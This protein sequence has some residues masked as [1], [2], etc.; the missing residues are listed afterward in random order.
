MD[1]VRF[2]E[3]HEGLEVLF[4]DVLIVGLQLPDDV[5]PAGMMVVGVVPVLAKEVFKQGSFVLGR[6]IGLV[7]VDISNG[8]RIRGLS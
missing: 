8:M 5:L 6:E 7:L 2:D 4:V 1:F 3:Q